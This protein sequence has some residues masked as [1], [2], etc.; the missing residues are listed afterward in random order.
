MEIRGFRGIRIN[1]SKIRM[2]AIRSGANE[3]ADSHH[4]K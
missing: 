2:S 3:S 1:F 4:I